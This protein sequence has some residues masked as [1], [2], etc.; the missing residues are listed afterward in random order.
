MQVQINSEI[1]N[2]KKAHTS[3]I[4]PKNC[5]NS[6]NKR[7]LGRSEDA[8]NKLI[9]KFEKNQ[10]QDTPTAPDQPP[11]LTTVEEFLFND[12]LIED[13][14]D[15]LGPDKLKNLTAKFTAT[16][17]LNVSESQSSFNVNRE[18]QEVLIEFEDSYYKSS[19]FSHHNRKKPQPPLA[20]TQPPN[21]LSH[22]PKKFLK[23]T[24][25]AY[26]SSSQHQP[27]SQ[28]QNHLQLPTTCNSRYERYID[29]G[30]EF[31]SGSTAGFKS[32]QSNS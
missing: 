22:P 26:T 16:P 5:Q 8:L 27:Q 7:I 21:K 30:N 13:L 10:Q 20:S 24:P 29:S 17:I 18:S 32:F 31:I 14:S 2:L 15:T 12:I 4:E 9:E 3:V 19:K 25:N 6:F 1:D 11:L 23:K 28:S